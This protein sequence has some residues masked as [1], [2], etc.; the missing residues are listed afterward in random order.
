MW[1]R[2]FRVVYISFS[3]FHVFHIPL[4]TSW[5]Q[6]LQISC[7]P[8]RHQ[9]MSWFMSEYQPINQMTG[10]LDRHLRC[11][12]TCLEE[13]GL[14]VSNKVNMKTSLTQNTGTS[15]PSKTCGSPKSGRSMSVIPSCFAPSHPQA[16]GSPC[17]ERYG[18]VTSRTRSICSGRYGRM[19]TI[20]R[21]PVKIPAGRSGMFERYIATIE[22]VF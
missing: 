19:D 3:D 7:S 14:S 1:D 2:S 8:V 13:T 6:L 15:P 18:R 17:V 4:Y 16:T 12:T 9:H 5:L 20:Q 11:D 22:R 10:R 21:A